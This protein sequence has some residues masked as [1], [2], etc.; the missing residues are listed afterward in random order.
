MRLQGHFTTQFDDYYAL[1]IDDP[2]RG[3]R[4]RKLLPRI[5]ARFVRFECDQRGDGR[6]SAACAALELGARGVAFVEVKASWL[7]TRAR[8][9]RGALM[10]VDGTC[11]LVGVP[12]NMGWREGP[13][14]TRSSVPEDVTHAVF[15]SADRK[16]AC[17]RWVLSV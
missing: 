9:A 17:I 2:S 7:A 10:L 11:A 5:L 15:V 3:P 13:T 16:G 4:P 1:G 14:L 8:Q 12:P 6:L